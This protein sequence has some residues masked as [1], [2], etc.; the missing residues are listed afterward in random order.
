[1]RGSCDPRAFVPIL[2]DPQVEDLKNSQKFVAT[3]NGQLTGFVGVNQKC[4]GWLYIDPGYYRRGIGKLLLE[5]GL[6][7]IGDGAYTIVLDGNQ[8]AVQLYLN[9]GF[10]EV[11]RFS[12]ENEGYP[13][14]CLRLERN[15]A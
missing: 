4:L 15:L 7:I 9:A 3:I 6:E 8:G 14:V 5:K 13:V 12:S 2:K 11:R 1:M 10:K